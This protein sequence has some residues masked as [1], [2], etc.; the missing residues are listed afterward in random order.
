MGKNPIY[1]RL[2]DEGGEL[3][4]STDFCKT[5]VGR[6]LILESTGGYASNLNGKNESMNG[7]AKGM[8]FAMPSGSSGI[9]CLNT[10]VK[11]TPYEK[12]YDIK[13]SFKDLTVFGCH[14]YVLNST[15][16][17]K[18]LVDYC[19]QTDLRN[20][21][22]NSDIDRY[23]MGYTSNT[24]KVV[25]YWDPTTNTIKRTYHCFLDAFDT[26][27]SPNQKHNPGALLLAECA[28]GHQN[29]VPPN[30]ADIQFQVSNFNIAT[31]AFPASECSTFQVPIPPQGHHFICK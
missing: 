18:A 12:W 17:H 3:V 1:I 6:N 27:V 13:P 23:F 29:I 24:T 16:T 2:L 11:M 25:L 19:S 31:S 21:V 20:I 15:V 7:N 4:N 8:L 28:T 9:F 30:E 26:K 22:T 10:R 5:V 14:V